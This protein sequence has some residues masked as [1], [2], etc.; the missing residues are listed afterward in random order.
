METVIGAFCAV[1]FE[2]LGAHAR[3]R[4]NEALIKF[5]FFHRL[6]AITVD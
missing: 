3:S 1:R 6:A 5:S 2:W 4:A